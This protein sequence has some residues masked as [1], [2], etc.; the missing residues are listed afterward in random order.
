MARVTIVTTQ[1]ATQANKSSQT[2]EPKLT[3]EVGALAL[4]PLAA[5]AVLH[6]PAITAQLDGR[7]ARDVASR[8]PGAPDR[9]DALHQQPTAA[10]RL[11]A[12]RPR[13]AQVAQ[14]L[15]RQAAWIH[16]G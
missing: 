10:V 7:A 9:L 15:V 4:P 1:I 3:L 14:P 6:E 16:P 5:E 11:P 2:L 12:A 13:Q 8:V